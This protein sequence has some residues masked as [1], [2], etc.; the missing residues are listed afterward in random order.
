MIIITNPPEKFCGEIVVSG[1]KSI[2]HRAL[3]IGAMARGAT[4]ITG[5][6][7]AE[8]CLSTMR[9][10]QHLGTKINFQ[11][12]KLLIEG[13][14]MGFKEPAEA[15]NTGNSGTT[16]RLL[17]GILSGQSFKT[18]LTGDQSLQRRPMK[19]V[20]EPLRS[21]GAV[22][23]GEGDGESLPLTVQGGNLKAVHYHSPKASAQVKSAVLLAG[24][25]ADG[26]TT[27]E[28]PY[29]SRNHSEL[30]LRQFGASIDSSACKI[31][32]EGQP[33]LRGCQVKVPGDISTAAFFMVAAAIIS[34]SDLLLKDVGINPT[35]S[36]VIEVLESMGADIKIVNERT[37]GF[38]PVA[39]IRVK[40][41]SKL[42]STSIS[43]SLVP[44][45]IDEIPVLAVAA[46]F[47]EGETV[48]SDASEL[49]VKESD[50][51]TE[52]SLQLSKFG[53]A[54]TEKEDGMVIKGG[55]PLTGTD[56]D[57]CGDHRIAMALAVAGLAAQ[58]ETA[59]H[60]AGVIGI[61]FPGFMPALRSLIV[62]KPFN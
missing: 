9:C 19:R 24:L 57:S 23:E 51:I 49:R 5:Y 1:D 45:L 18:N 53:V 13:R 38:E 50:R 32:V 54:I 28:E 30:M 46:A 17:M 56:V 36:G 35:R 58:G 37:W 39:D 43:G 29:P 40:G 8:D 60:N 34:E 11:G 21:M 44:R 62:K 12:S 6:L 55:A 25:Y 48:I 10:L 59:V 31:S 15:L 2:T 61:S 16:V 47:A 33:Q 22:I 4:E 27:V 42:N 41:G 26:S 7:D 20:V 14:N 52:L 3:M